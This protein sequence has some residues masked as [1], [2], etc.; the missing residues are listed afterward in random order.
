MRS[1]IER[2]PA[3]ERFRGLL[4]SAPDAMMI[5]DREGRI[6]LANA[7]SDQLFGYD[8]DELRELRVEDL[9]PERLRGIHPGHRRE[10]F[11]SP[12]VR[13]MGADLELLGMRKD[14]SEFPV[15]ISLGPIETED[16]TVVSVAIRDTSDRRRI[17]QALREKNVELERASLAKDRFLAGMSHELR[18]PLNAII[19]FTGTLLMQLPGPLTQE[20]EEQ[21][22]IVQS[23]ARHLLSLINDILDLAKIESGKVDLH[24]EP[25]HVG[26]V[27]NEVAMAL[28]SLAHERGLGLGVT[29]PDAA[30]LLNTDRRAL[31]QILINLTNNAIKYTESGS[32]HIDV[33]ETR[34]E[35]RD[36]LD[37]SVVDTGVGID[38]E[39]RERI[40]EAFVQLDQSTT[41]R[42]DG[43]GLGLYLSRQ[44]AHLL[45]GELSLASEPGKGTT[46]TLSLPK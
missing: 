26:E 22:R 7:Q 31:R 11:L 40:F 21:L 10:F 38:D 32:V 25:V 28:R 34:R 24:F 9:I 20:Q 4:E 6:L 5:V 44:L 16:G 43:A 13:P 19:G 45:G 29:V 27:V 30:S 18:T 46:F 23:S 14:G 35:G 41:R 1:E 36:A 8:A 37:F 2:W 3:F 42:F 15:E 17:Q 39:A 12:R 33:A